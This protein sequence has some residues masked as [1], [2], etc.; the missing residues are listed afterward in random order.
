MRLHECWTEFSR[1]KPIDAQRERVLQLLSNARR[2][3]TPR[4]WVFHLILIVIGLAIISAGLVL[5]DGPKQG[6]A[7]IFLFGRPSK[8][9]MAP[10][11]R[12][13]DRKTNPLRQ[14][15][16][17]SLAV[18]ISN[19]NNET[20]ADEYLKDG[21]RDFQI[22]NECGESKFYSS[23]AIRHAQLGESPKSE[24]EFRLRF[25]CTVVRYEAF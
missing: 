2:R 11:E 10:V 20:I 24:Y 19:I 25:R 5:P 7:S 22:W 9:R 16:G 15:V 23:V 17:Q 1:S 4:P 14:A 6:R 21:P 8:H 3:I 13:D 12:F 18:Y